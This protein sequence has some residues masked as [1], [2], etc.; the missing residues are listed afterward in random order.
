MLKNLLNKCI[1][2]ETLSE[3]ES[4]Q[5]MDEIMSGRATSSQIASLLTIL[6]FRGET[7]E[8]ITGF[9]RAMREHM[10]PLDYEDDQ[11]ID[12]CGT[13]GDGTS[14]FNISTAAAIVVSSLGIRVAK[15]GNRAVSSNS[16]S[17]DV[18]EHL[19]IEIQATK[20]QAK[21]AL[22]ERGLSFLFA[23]IYHSAMKHAVN[24]RR[25][26]GFRT[27]FNLLG[28]M[29]NP[30]KCKKQVIGV[31]SISY[32]EKMAHA[33]QKLGSEHVLFVTGRDGLDECSISAETDIVELKNGKISKF[34]LSPEDVGLQRGNLSDIQVSTANE[35]AA[36]LKDVLFG[37]ANESAV[38]I[39]LFNA[40]VAIYI[41]GRSSSIQNGVEIAKEAI[42]SGLVRSHFEKLTIREVE[43]YA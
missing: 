18:L 38:N 19:G 40:G 9:A 41:S 20:E 27:V 26:I 8:E 4:Y 35:S 29:A 24:P 33:L 14:T 31:F 43:N 22:K 10:L 42:K 32:A 2:G 34:V 6:R 5:V 1:S 12:T 39:V 30:A 15:H 28:P 13:G 37:N 3:T 7:I 23:P 16:G 36:L 21:Q 17:A 25:E 11:I